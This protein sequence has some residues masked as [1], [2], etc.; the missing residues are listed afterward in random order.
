MFF[1]NS[2]LALL[3]AVVC[4]DVCVPFTDTGVHLVCRSAIAGATLFAQLLSALNE[5]Y[6][7]PSGAVPVAIKAFICA[8]KFA[9]QVINGWLDVGML[10]L[11]F[12]FI[13]P[14]FFGFLG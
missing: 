7:N 10:V 3:K 8:K 5:K 2:F 4:T 9:N 13:S 12:L 6:G 14:M 11:V 1:K